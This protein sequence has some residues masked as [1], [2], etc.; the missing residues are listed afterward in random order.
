MTLNGQPGKYRILGIELSGKEVYA[1]SELSGKWVSRDRILL[2]EDKTTF[3]N[4]DQ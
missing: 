4:N 1:K 3:F 2:S